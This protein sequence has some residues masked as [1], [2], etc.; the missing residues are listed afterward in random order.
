MELK[1]F[2]VN[3]SDQ[4]DDTDPAEI[5]E[6]TDF[7]DLDEW[8]SLIGMSVVA[9]VKSKYGKIISNND[10]TSCTTVEELFKLISEK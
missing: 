4:F 10:I 6:S 1:E 5:N 2:I 3:F 8:S 9:M 7:K